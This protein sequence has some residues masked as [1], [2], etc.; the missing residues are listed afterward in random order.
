MIT[1]ESRL[2]EILCEMDYEDGMQLASIVHCSLWSATILTVHFQFHDAFLAAQQDNR[3]KLRGKIMELLSDAPTITPIVH[4]TKE[5]H[6]FNDFLTAS[7][8]CPM[9]YLAELQAN[10]A[11]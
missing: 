2:R 5:K 7:K 4:T 10:S 9:K 1:R 11:E 6:G 8:L 3:G